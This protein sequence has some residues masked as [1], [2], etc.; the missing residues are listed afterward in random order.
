M[1]PIRPI[2]LLAGVGL[3]AACLCAPGLGSAQQ[4]RADAEK[5]PLLKAM[6]EEL[7]RSKSELQLKGFE[8]PFF[9]QYRIEDADNFETKAEFG[10][11]EGSSHNHQRVARVTVRVGDYKTD[12]SGG[13]GDGALQLVGLDDD[14]IAVRSALWAATDQAYK[15]ALAAYAQKQAALKEVQTP[16]QADD[17]S[18][19]KP[20]I[21]LEEP[22]TL[23]VDETAWAERVAR[24]SGL[25]RTDAQVKAS[26]RDVQYSSAEFHARVTTTWLATSEGT[27][28]RKPAAEY[29]EA[30]A[31]GTQAA[32]GMRLD[33]S[34]A[35][36][37]VS[38]KDLDSPPVFEKHAVELIASL[39]DLRKAP[40]VEEEYHGPVLL[41]SDAGADTLR[42]LVAGAVTATRPKLG[43]EARTNGPFASSYHARVL[44]EFLDVV[45]DPGLKSYAGRSLLGAY[46]VD[47]EGVPAQA[48]KLVTVGRLENYLIG[49]EPVKDF[50]ESNGHG[51]AGITG[52]PRPAIG[53]LQV[54]AKVGLS[55]GELDRKL[56]DL[57]HDRGLKSVY[58][59][60]TL[61]GELTPRLLYRV[62]LDGKRELVRGAVL[63]DLDQRALR[64]S[65]VAAGKDLWVANYFGDV[66]RTVLAPALLLD[67][68]TIRRAN[69][70][71]EK[72]PFYPPPE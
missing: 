41:S 31:V 29:E 1:N 30:F 56:V 26:Q 20:V 8:K 69:E 65:V 47:D 51:R 35:S 21:V 45:D 37:G 6:L 27:I 38:L 67:D 66:P 54:T 58:Y 64:S 3:L 14:P 60:Q 10:A 61:G 49:R 13:R 44:P 32:D 68:V 9:I 62:G 12:S 28:V 34:Y 4:T 19:E 43:T 2:A 15:S 70:K 36:V 63:G 55:D 52:A 59:V 53:V 11:S 16:P 48:V 39:T 23:K 50:P 42:E 33:R 7:D 40:L 22:L 72:L 25:Y 5:D 17:F 71:N 18:Q 46:D 24:D 57:G